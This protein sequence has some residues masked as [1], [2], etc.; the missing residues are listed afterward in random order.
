MK[1]EKEFYIFVKKRVALGKAKEKKQEKE[2]DKFVKERVAVDKARVK[3]RTKKEKRSAKMLKKISI[4]KNKDNS[5]NNNNINNKNNNIFWWDE[6]QPSDDSSWAEDW[7]NECKDEQEFD[8]YRI[9][10]L[11]DY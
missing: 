6:S 1:E 7:S 2:F 9:L 10:D 5:N 4:N 3:K 11:I 8:L